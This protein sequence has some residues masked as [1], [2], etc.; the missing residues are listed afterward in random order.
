MTILWGWG[1]EEA[2]SFP[3]SCCYAAGLYL[4]CELLVFKAAVEL[5][6]GDGNRAT[7]HFVLTKI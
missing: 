6:K 3:S 7:N 2:G 1:F 5:R 4:D